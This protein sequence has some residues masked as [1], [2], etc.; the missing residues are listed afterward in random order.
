MKLLGLRWR[1]GGFVG[2]WNGKRIT[3]FELRFKV[4]FRSWYWK[5]IFPSFSGAVLWFCFRLG[6]EWEYGEYIEEARS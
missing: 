4:F 3:G 5:P 6:F 1:S 2:Y